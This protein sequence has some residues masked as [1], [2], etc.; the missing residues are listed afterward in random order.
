MH[1]SS[2]MF[3]YP[4]ALF[5]A[6]HQVVTV[7]HF[8]AAAEAQNG[9]DVGGGAAFDAVGILHVIGDEPAADL[10]AVGSAHHHGV[11]AAKAALDLDDA[12]RQQTL[13][14]AQR[15]DRARVDG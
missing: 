4:G 11:A 13:A 15:L 8:G 1:N 14:R 3:G 2:A 5:A 12:G 9:N 7:D 6:H 10:G